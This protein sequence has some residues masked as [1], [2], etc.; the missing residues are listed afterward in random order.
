[1]KMLNKKKYKY[2]FLV[3][4]LLRAPLVDLERYENMVSEPD[5]KPAQGSRIQ[6]KTET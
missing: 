6:K 5:S 1:M 3:H 2:V 4:E